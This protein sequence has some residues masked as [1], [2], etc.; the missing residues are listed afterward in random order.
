MS[1]DLREFS[2]DEIRAA[3]CKAVL[4]GDLDDELEHI[5][6]ACRRRRDEWRWNFHVNQ[7]VRIVRREGAYPSKWDGAEGYVKTIND[8][9]VSVDTDRGGVRV[10]PSMLEAVTA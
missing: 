1:L 8:K 7:R 9:T 10:H 4:Y 3:V 6:N 2:A 5:V